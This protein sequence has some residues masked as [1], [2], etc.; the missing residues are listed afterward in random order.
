MAKE[1]KIL[2]INFPFKT[3]WVVQEPTL[4]TQRA[5]FDFHVVVIRPYLLLGLPSGGPLDVDRY[6]AFTHARKEMAAKIGDIDRLLRQGGL[7]VIVLNEVQEFTFNTGKHSYTGGTLYTTTNYDFLHQHFFG[8]LSNGKGENVVTMAADPF[9]PVITKSTVEWT[10]FIVAR[11]PDPFSDPAYFA[12]NGDKSYVGGR[13]SLSAGNVVFLPNFKQ[14]N[15]EQFFEACREY[16]YERQGSPVPAWCEKIA[17]PGLPAADERIMN[18]NE[19]LRR[20][21]QAKREAVRERDDLLAYK[22]LLYEK[23]KTQLEPIVR[24]ALNEVGFKCTTGETLP[25]TG[26]EIDGRTTVGSSQ[27]ILEIKGSKKQIA[28]DE[29]SPFVPKILADFKAKGTQSKGIFVG[30]GLCEMPPRD[31]LGEKVFSPHVLEAAKTQSVALLNTIELYCV[32]SGALSGK[33]KTQ[34][35]EQIREKVLNTNGFASLIEYC[36]EL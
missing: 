1:L 11:P 12:R 29:Y 36:K 16:M 6:S 33:V 21:E 35:L 15:E 14:L 27:G 13:V 10:A 30:N 20:V 34:E 7:L 5:L 18:I 22:K 31:R 28:L 26:F 17:L 24:R 4:A 3:P 23:G 8:C 2:S 32:V 19:E 9:L 25:G